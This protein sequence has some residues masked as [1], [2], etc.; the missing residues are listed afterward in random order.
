MVRMVSLCK[1]SARKPA[2]LLG[3]VSGHHIGIASY[4][5]LKTKFDKGTPQCVM[6]ALASRQ[7]CL[8]GAFSRLQ[9][10]SRRATNVAYPSSLGPL[11]VDLTCAQLTSATSSP[12]LVQSSRKAN[13]LVSCLHAGLPSGTSERG[14]KGRRLGGAQDSETR[15]RIV[16][17]R[18]S[19]DVTEADSGKCKGGA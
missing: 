2:F 15:R 19:E 4:C 16:A 3:L 1:V 5:C 8:C 9:P 11:Q 13:T 10:A 17:R 6:A 12:H 14:V 7:A 18:A